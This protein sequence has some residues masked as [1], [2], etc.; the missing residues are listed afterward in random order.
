[1]D[2]VRLG[3]SDLKVS[4]VGLGA[5]QLGEEAWGWGPDYGEKEARGVLEKAVELGIN[6]IDTAEIYGNGT[7][8]K[9]LGEFL[10]QK[11]EEVLV[12]TKVS[13]QHLRY[14]DVFKA[15]DGSLRRLGVKEV[16]LYQ[17][18][19]PNYYV[20]IKETVKALE[21]LLKQGKV[22]H[23]GVSNFPVSMLKEVLDTANF[24]VVSNQLRYNLLQREVEQ[25]IKP[26]CENE[27]ITVIAYSPLAQGL[28]SGKYSAADKPRDKVRTQNPLFREET[29]RAVDGLLRTLKEIATTRGK[30]MAQVA[31]NWLLA[32]RDVVPIPGAKRPEQIEE[33][34]GGAGW[35]LRAEEIKRISKESERVKPSYYTLS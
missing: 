20:P 12:A 1:M 26:F 24:E 34:S 33:L 7:S 28:L 4:V 32:M 30:T 14:N 9:I 8:E 27:K 10:K 18:H 23:V 15:V 16:D 2:Y 11:H 21:T 19:W 22:R 17:V 25:E 13:G 5:W 29:L 31:I 3:K 35:R 6:I